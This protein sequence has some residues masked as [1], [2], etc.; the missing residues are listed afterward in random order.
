ME[1]EDADWNQVNGVESVLHQLLCS[2]KGP[3]K[4]SKNLKV[5]INGGQDPDGK[6]KEDC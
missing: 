2:L 4:Q 1:K 5:E 3:W 6:G